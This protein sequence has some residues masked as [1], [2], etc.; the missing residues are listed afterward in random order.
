MDQRR[1]FRPDRRLDPQLRASPDW[2]DDRRR[3]A[4]FGVAHSP[5]T[6]PAPY[7][8][9]P[10]A[11][12]AD[13]DRR[14]QSWSHFAG[15]PDWRGGGDPAGR[16]GL[17]GRLP[18]GAAVLP[19]PL[20]GRILSVE[21]PAGA[22]LMTEP[23]GAAVLFSDGDT[24]VTATIEIGAA[25]DFTRAVPASA[26]AMLLRPTVADDEL[27]D[28]VLG[29]VERLHDEHRSAFERATDIRDFVRERYAYDPSYLEDPAIAAWLRQR[30]RGRSN[31]HVAAL[32]AGAD[33]EHLGR[34][35]CY[36]LN[37]LACE[38]LRRAGVPAVIA[39]GWTLDRGFVDEPDH[40][41]AMALLDAGDGP[42][43]LPVDASTTRAGRP[44]HA[45]HRPPGPWR[46]AESGAVR[47]PGWA[48][49]GRRAEPSA[50]PP[51]P[52]VA[53]LLRVA[54]YLEE[55]TGR[56]LGSRDELAAALRE[57]LRDPD[58]AAT[59]AAFLGGDPE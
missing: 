26:D 7:L 15:E 32:H 57:L 55:T 41:F 4:S 11:L 8:Y 59:L 53:E 40:L 25:P 3:A 1:W 47:T 31:E 30:S 23:G 9:A 24:L 42:R 27:P 43:W 48:R 36:E 49:A 52:P 21:D 12:F 51:R 19:L 39:T 22:R 33:P 20:Y 6:L 37:L 56:R 46:A 38:L 54:R 10:V 14:R 35:V 2:L 17:R 18:G 5:R 44:L 58:R 45:G 29:L 13:F 50:A 16:V 34:G 28:E